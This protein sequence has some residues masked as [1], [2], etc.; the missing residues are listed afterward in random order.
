[1]GQVKVNAAIMDIPSKQALAAAVADIQDLKTQVAA[2][3]V[4]ITAMRTALSAHTH[5]GVTA[6]AANTSASATLSALTAV[7]PATQ[8]LIL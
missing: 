4:D 6:G 8:Q 1:M 2:L 5:G 7:A 3:V